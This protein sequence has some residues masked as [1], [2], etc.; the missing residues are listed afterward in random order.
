M[1]ALFLAGKACAEVSVSAELSQPEAQVGEVVE[2]RVQVNGTQSA[3]LPQELPVED[4]QIRMT[5]QS[6]QVQMVNFKVSSSVVYSYAI[7]GMRPGSFTIPSVPVRAGGREFRT[8]QLRLAVRDRSSPGGYAAIPAPAPPVSAVQAG[9]ASPRGAVAQPGARS[10]RSRQPSDQD[11]LAFGEIECAKTKIYA[12]EAVPVEI[13][14]LFDASYPVQVRGKVDFGGEGVI[15][16]RFPEPKETREERD[17]VVYNVLTF[18]TVLSAV[19]T[20]AIEIAPAK[21][22]CQMQLPGA[23]PPGFDDP[24]FQQLMGGRSPFGQ[25]RDLAVRTAPLRLEVLPLPKEERP[26]SFAGAVGQFDLDASVA[27]PRPAPGDPATLTLKVSGKGNFKAMGAPVLTGTEGW[28][29]YPPTDK[30]DDADSLSLSGV[31]SFDF[32]L[33][34]QQ[35]MKL[36][37]GGAFSYFDPVAAKYVTLTTPPLPLEA[38]P[39]TGGSSSAGAVPASA[40][41]TPSSSPTAAPAPPGKGP[42]AAEGVPLDALTF[43]SW[44]ATMHRSEFLIASA[45]LLV[46]ALSLAGFLR[47]LQL[48]AQGGTP[49]MRRRRR[50]AQLWGALQ[51]GNLDAAS[52]YE[53]AIEY[54]VLVDTTPDSR[55]AA[56]PGLQERR[57][58]LKYGSGG[59]VALGD[60]ER[61]RVLGTLRGLTAKPPR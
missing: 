7:L 12:G 41:A 45:A 20:G 14:F 27:T 11:R 43:R 35:P 4:L 18:R 50:L 28:R 60:S 55:E 52:F 57:D 46:A 10:T 30:L 54:A 3:E 16:E 51:S 40:S 47:Y 58:V 23:L 61:E 49:A 6:T 53:A 19:K 9:S 15:A 42:Q 59:P 5:G 39:G 22:D 8:P 13:R 36:S 2:L 17:G 29:S 26:D 44:R 25:T 24:V 32:T 38:W 48:H 37:P 31:K 56:L 21:L 34:A 33:I 1:L